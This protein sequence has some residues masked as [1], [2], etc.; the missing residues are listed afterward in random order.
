MDPRF[1]VRPPRLRSA[2]TAAISAALHLAGFVGAIGAVQAGVLERPPPPEKS[3]TFVM[4]INP[5]LSPPIVPRAPL[6]ADLASVVAP[7]RPAEEPVQPAAPPVSQPPEPAPET[8][9]AATPMPP[10]PEPFAI[11]LAD[12]AGAASRAG[13]VVGAFDRPPAQ[14]ANAPRPIEPATAAGFGADRPAV[15]PV[16][17][18][19][20]VQAGGFELVRA[21][22][23]PAAE[24]RS[25]PTE[26]PVEIVFKPTPD[27]TDEAIALRIQGDVALEI[28]FAASGDVRILRVVSGLGHGLDEAAVRA[29][30]R[31]RFKPAARAG[32]PV[33]VRATVHIVFRLS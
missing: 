9:E 15:R 2:A 11:V 27:Y 28:E 26:T 19:Q 3:L 17:R 16:H 29:A 24:T 22:A 1:A 21:S 4:M 32:R 13:P 6:D 12:A 14:R 23:T 30:E 33:D 20:A 18:V 10:S 25:E 7:V 8:P 5:E 31:I